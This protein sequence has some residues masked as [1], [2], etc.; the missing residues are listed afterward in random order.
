MIW[1]MWEIKKKTR[2][3]HQRVRR[4]VNQ[5]RTR[6]SIE[7]IRSC[8]KRFFFKGFRWKDK[9]IFRRKWKIKISDSEARGFIKGHHG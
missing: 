9:K 8:I 4:K 7:S 2:G 6:K 1:N 3:T 5:E